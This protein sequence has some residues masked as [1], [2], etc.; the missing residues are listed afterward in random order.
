[1]FLFTTLLL[2]LEIRAP[3]AGSKFNLFVSNGGLLLSK[4]DMFAFLHLLECGVRDQ[5]CVRYSGTLLADSF[6]LKL[7]IVNGRKH[8]AKW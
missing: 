4:H 6:S 2:Q 3:S 8:V 5:Q 1:M 7:N